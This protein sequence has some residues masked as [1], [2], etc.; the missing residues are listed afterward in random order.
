MAGFVFTAVI[1]SAGLS[2]R[3]GRF[4]PLLPLND[5]SIL[6]HLILRYQSCGISDIRVVAGYRADEVVALAL[7]LGATPVL[8]PDYTN[9]MWSSVVAGVSGL[10]TCTSGFFIHPVDIPLV[11]R[12]TFLDLMAAYQPASIVYPTFRHERGHPPL[13]ARDFIPDLITYD[14]QGGLRKF[15]SRHETRSI[16]IA[17]ADRFILK[18]IDELADYHWA[19]QCID[20][21]DIPSID[22]C[23]ELMTR[24]LHVPDRVLVHCEAVAKLAE[25]IGKALTDTGCPL[26]IDCIVSAAL[27]HDLTRSSPEHARTGAAL[28]RDMD[29]PRLADIVEVHMDFS[30]IRDAPITE[31]EVVFL[32]DKLIEVDHVV[33]LET[34]YRDKLNRYGRDAEAQ[35]RITM[36]MKQAMTSRIRIEKRI[37][38]CILKA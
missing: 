22:E 6:E 20:R 35:K 31:A 8:N 24:C 3:L 14:G 12:Q 4:K 7:R 25:S 37:G 16:E 5:R 32:A 29:F 17:A 11:R 1:L 27:I 38:R 36:R 10:P 34:R 28:L 13:I 18:D 33:D 9:G 23:R 26:D 30:T 19:V 21:Y 2:S 15:L